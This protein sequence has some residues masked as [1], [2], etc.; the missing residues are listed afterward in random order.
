MRN[1]TTVLASDADTSFNNLVH[2]EYS[3]KMEVDLV[4]GTTYNVIVTDT[5]VKNSGDWDRVYYKQI[6][7]FLPM[8]I[9]GSGAD[10]P[11]GSIMAFNLSACPTGWV[12]ADG[13]SG[14]PDL[15]GEFIR[16]LDS[17]RGVDTGRVIGSAQ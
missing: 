17:G 12:I 3:G 14:A 2:V 15:R 13:S 1:G 5:G 16:G 11:V 10:L 8:T 4:A 9:A 6:A 7:G